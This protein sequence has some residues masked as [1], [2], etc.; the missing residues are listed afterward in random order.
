MAA[1]IGEKF[2]DYLDNYDKSNIHE[3]LKDVYQD[4]PNDLAQMNHI[5]LYGPSGVGKYTQAL[6]LISKYSKSRLKYERKA[7]ICQNKDQYYY[8]LSDVHIEIDM[9]MLGPSAKNLWMEIITQ[10]YDIINSLNKKEFIVLCKNFDKTRDELME[11]F[12]SYLNNTKPIQL[13]YIFVTENPS[14]LPESILNI[15]LMLPI[16]RSSVT[17]HKTLINEKKGF[18]KNEISKISNI[19]DYV[20]NNAVSGIDYNKKIVSAL[21]DTIKHH[22]SLDIKILRNQIYYI[23]TYNL[24]VKTC[25]K[26]LLF[27]IL[28][29]FELSSIKIKKIFQEINNFYKLY[30]NNY[31]P[32]YHIENLVITLIKIIHDL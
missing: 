15:C 11:I 16:K 4:M 23:F 24:C 13:K 6:A 17:T 12:Y 31:R 19:K 14:V 10:L 20:F 1:I 29:V 30:N 28:K 18:T 5:I 9:E 3:E 2:T 21:L 25:I 32:I 8:K 26:D 7:I 27:S 22:E